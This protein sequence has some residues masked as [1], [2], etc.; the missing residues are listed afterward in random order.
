MVSA[1]SRQRIRQISQPEE[2]CRTCQQEP[3]GTRIAIHL[4]LDGQQQL[5]YPLDLID[6]QQ[7]MS[8]LPTI[9]WAICRTTSGRSADIG[10]VQEEHSS[11]AA[12]LL[13]REP[14]RWLAAAAG[15]AAAFADIAAAGRAHLGAAGEAERSV[16]RAALLGLR[17]ARS[18]CA[19][20]RAAARGRRSLSRGWH[21][22]RSA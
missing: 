2:A 21:A 18:S 14:F 11:S 1:A 8:V 9:S 3:A 7:A 4:P 6:H 20:R 16:G 19:A 15:G 22:V 12:L 10:R 13:N 5:R 17:S